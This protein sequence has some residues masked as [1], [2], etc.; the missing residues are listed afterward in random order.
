MRASRQRVMDLGQRGPG[1]RGQFGV[2]PGLHHARTDE[3]GFEF[4]RVEQQR[5]HIKAIAQAVTDPGFALD[6]HARGAQIADVPVQGAQ[7]D[8]KLV[9][10]PGASGEAPA[11]QQLDK[12]KQA[13]SA[14]HRR[15]AGATCAA[16]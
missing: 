12:A 6:G 16:R 1:R 7:R 10:Q 2:T 5:R 4:L 13:V 15:S 8:F 11:A 14:S 9:G 3:Q